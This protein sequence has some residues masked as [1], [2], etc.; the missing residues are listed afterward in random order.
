MYEV[1]FT[2]KAVT[3]LEKL[4]ET[5]RLRI[6]R[7]L[8]EYSNSPLQFARKLSNPQLGAY[9]FRIGDF[10]AI[11]DLVGEKIVILRIGNRKDIYR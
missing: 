1:V 8:K 4:D 5:T 6:A 10:R 9:R 2:K 7:K 11:F 3:D